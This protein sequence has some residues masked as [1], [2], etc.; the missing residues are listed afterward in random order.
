MDILKLAPELMDRRI[1]IT[2]KAGDVLLFSS[3]ITHGSSDN[4]STIPH[5]RCY[6]S[7]A[8][9]GY[10]SNHR[11]EVLYTY[12]NGTHPARYAH[13]FTGNEYNSNVKHARSS[14]PQHSYQLGAIGR[15][16]VGAASWTDPVV[17]QDLQVFFSSNKQQQN[18]IVRQ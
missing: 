15:A 5:L 2:A 7:M 18:Q 4:N 8:P 14:R 11:A 9:D 6:P 3:L 16:L 10:L 12:L 13:F 1:S 17:V